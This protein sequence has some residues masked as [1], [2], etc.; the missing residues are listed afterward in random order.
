M[1]KRSLTPASVLLPFSLTLLAPFGFSAP[2]QAQHRHYNAYG[3][4][5]DLAWY[6]HYRHGASAQLVLREDNAY[7]WKCNLRGRD[8]GIDVNDVCRSIYGSDTTPVMGN[9]NDRASWYCQQN[10]AQN[11]PSSPPPSNPSGNNS[12]IAQEMVAAHNQ[13]RSRVGVP[14]L[15]WSPQLASYAQKWANHLASTGQFSHRPQQQYGENLFWG[16]GRRWSPT[17]VVNNWGSEVKDYDYG[18]N[19]C[20]DVCG[21]YT[22]VVWARTTEVGCA[23]ARSGNEEVWVCNYNPPGNYVGQRPY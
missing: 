12:A 5:M 13:W 21:H 23:V 18:S 7:G 9:F 16:S 15:R 22:Q 6:C 20:R 14:P 10:T 3:L 17:E 19:S 2:T 11:Q 1:I 8:L 4:G